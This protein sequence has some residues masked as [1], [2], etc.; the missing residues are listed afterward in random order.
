MAAAKTTA[1][2]QKEFKSAKKAEG[3]DEI[4]NLWAHKDDHEAVKRFAQMVSEKRIRGE[5]V[6]DEW[7]KE[8]FDPVKEWLMV[9]GDQPSNARRAFG[10]VQ[11]AIDEARIIIGDDVVLE[12]SH[13]GKL[14]LRKT[15]RF[16]SFGVLDLKLDGDSWVN[17]VF[18]AH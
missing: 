5:S 12:T 16:R 1:Q 11:V 7:S 14:V 8:V 13:Q 3:M 9:G 17:L 4:H 2:R 6:T 10:M 18:P 15:Y